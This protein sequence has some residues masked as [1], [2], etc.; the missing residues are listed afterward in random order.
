MEQ[1]S[2]ATN[3]HSA[4]F[5]QTDFSLEVGGISCLIEATP[6]RCVNMGSTHD[7]FNSA[8]F[9]NDDHYCDESRLH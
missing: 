3:T 6:G 9:D 8:R 5:L 7:D 1:N 4:S 2:G